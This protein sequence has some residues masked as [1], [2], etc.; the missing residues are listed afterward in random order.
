MRKPLK[1]APRLNA[2]DLSEDIAL[3]RKGP[4]CLLLSQG[5]SDAYED[6]TTE[7]APAAP[8]RLEVPRFEETMIAGGDMMD[9]SALRTLHNSLQRVMSEE[10]LMSEICRALKIPQFL[11]SN[12]GESQAAACRHSYKAR[13]V[14]GPVDEGQLQ[15]TLHASLQ[16]VLSSQ[17]DIDDIRK[18]VGAF[19]AHGVS[20]KKMSV[21]RKP[22]KPPRW[23][24]DG[25]RPTLDADMSDIDLEF[26]ILKSGNDRTRHISA[27]KSARVARD[28][29]GARPAA[30]RKKM[31]D[32]VKRALRNLGISPHTLAGN[33]SLQA[34]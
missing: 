12:A 16:R 34:R 25:T 24:S 27:R 28:E 8:K 9:D 23:T 6:P 10:D 14:H 15:E 29:T 20:E 13:L 19:P 3:R 11:A 26:T 17:L 30:G 5:E 1:F 7:Y 33:A 21:V 18:T 4:S 31:H 32:S 22:L 2:A